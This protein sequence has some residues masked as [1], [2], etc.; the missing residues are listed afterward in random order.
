[1]D[2]DKHF[3]VDAPDFR[4]ALSTHLRYPGTKRLYF[5]DILGADA[6]SQPL[7]YRYI[8]EQAAVYCARNH[9]RIWNLNMS[10]PIVRAKIVAR[11]EKGNLDVSD[12]LA[13]YPSGGKTD[14]MLTRILC[15][16]EEDMRQ[17]VTQQLIDLHCAFN[18]P[19]FYVPKENLDLLF[20]GSVEYH[21][22]TD[23]RGKLLPNGCYVFADGTRRPHSDYQAE[24]QNLPDP[25]DLVQRVLHQTTCVFA[26]EKRNELLGEQRP[27]TKIMFVNSPTRDRGGFRGA[28]TSLLYAVGPLV[29]AIKSRDVEVTGFSDVNIWDPTYFTDDALAEF[30]GKLERMKPGIVGISSTSD[31]FQA[32]T[33]IANEV[34]RVLPESVVIIGGPHCDEVRFDEPD[35]PNNPIAVDSPFDFAIA[36]EGEWMLKELVRVVSTA[37]EAG[38]AQT[39]EDV[40]ARVLASDKLFAGVEGKAKLYF[41][42]D[43][44]LR[45]FQSSWRPIRLS[46]LPP[47]RMEYL[48][49]AH[50]YDFEVFRHEDESAKRCIQV[51]THRGCGGTC[52][53]CTERLLF[54]GEPYYNRTRS[55]TDVIEEILH[56]ESKFGIEAVF[57]DDSTFIEQDEFVKELCKKM[58]DTGLAKRIEWGCLNRFDK[59]RSAELIALM[60]DAGMSYMYLGLELCDDKALR[61]MRK[62]ITRETS[63]GKVKTKKSKTSM[64]QH[65]SEAL[66]MLRGAGVTAGVSILFGLPKEEEEVE[67]RTIEYVGEKVD[68][69]YISLVS[70]SL[71]NYHLGS[72]MTD[73]ALDQKDLNYRDVA[74]QRTAEQLSAPWNCFEEGGWFDASV[75]NGRDVTEEYLW[76]LLDHVDRHIT[77][78]GVLVRERLI[79]E[80]MRKR[81]TPRVISNGANAS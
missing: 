19:L 65:M 47:L 37:L 58:I 34:R 55:V 26:A 18:I 40:I 72:S 73:A 11:L 76:R 44:R 61:R 29:E 56:Y 25:V 28:P 14:L 31:S 79:K 8:Y 41:L 46:E 39:R 80:A 71:L 81:G 68:A 70:L 69:Q 45:A 60:A 21:A 4:E 52:S 77:R 62:H 32:A 23:D 24:R 48:D 15:W 54:P 30:A 12:V 78:P 10:D 2:N 7:F 66:E 38:D 13:D 53:F 36:G 35:N 33:H 43:Q 64:V 49:P 16:P 67:L 50:F 75:V 42:A 6:W 63:T 74:N 51:M 1:M 22:A 17:E 3:G 9:T 27:K 20:P 57:F 59:I 5:L